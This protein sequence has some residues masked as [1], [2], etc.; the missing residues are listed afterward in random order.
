MLDILIDLSENKTEGLISVIVPVYNIEAYLPRC[1]E[2][3]K[4]QTYTN[5]EIIL[6]DD[7]STDSS[8]HLCDAF[9]ATDSRAQV[10]HQENKGL[11]AA[12]NAGQNVATGEFLWFPDGDDY[13]HKNILYLMMEAINQQDSE[14]NKYDLAIVGHRETYRLDEDCST[15]VEPVFVELSCDEIFAALVRPRKSFTGRNIWN[16]LCRKSFLGDIRTGNYRYAQDCDFSIK[17][18]KKNPRIIFIKNDLYWFVQRPTSASHSLGYGLISSQC[19]TRIAYEHLMNRQL[20]DACSKRYLLEFLYICIAHWL[21]Y[22]QN[23]DSI[24]SARQES[25]EMIRRTWLSYLACR[26]IR[27]P[28]HRLGRLLRVRFDGIYRICK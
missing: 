25:R 15:T 7:G 16:K 10:I 9:A 6:V 22:A 8:G 12:R 4:S 14:G 18:Y 3:I 20:Q 26:E 11:W 27:T 28:L 2:G 13:F 24:S 17:L 21:N 1:L 5:L 23:T 19:M